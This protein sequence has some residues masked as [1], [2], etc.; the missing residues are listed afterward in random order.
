MMRVRNEEISLCTDLVH[1]D[2]SLSDP[3]P[4]TPPFRST[5]VLIPLQKVIHS[6]PLLFVRL[7]TAVDRKSTRLNSSHSGESRM[8]SSA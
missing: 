2:L 3:L 8:P 6:P 5:L 4:L 1:I 7:L